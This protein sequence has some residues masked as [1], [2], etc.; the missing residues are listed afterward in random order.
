MSQIISV[1]DRQIVTGLIRAAECGGV[2]VGLFYFFLESWT[3]HRFIS[4]CTTVS[5][6][7]HRSKLGQ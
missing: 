6:D 4:G 7:S 3:G 2:V 1:T 5:C